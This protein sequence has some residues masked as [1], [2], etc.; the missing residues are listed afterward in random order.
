MQ[1][2][3]ANHFP[4]MHTLNYWSVRQLNADRRLIDPDWMIR[5]SLSQ[6]KQPCPWPNSPHCHFALCCESDAP[7]R[8]RRVSKHTNKK[9]KTSWYG[10]AEALPSP[11]VH[12]WRVV[13]DFQQTESSL[14]PLPHLL[15][16][17]SQPREALTHAVL[18]ERQDPALL[19][20]YILYTRGYI[21]TQLRWGWWWRWLL[22][23]L[24]LLHL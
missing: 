9:G 23:M 11:L 24:Q 2:C 1:M 6:Q 7:V 20:P 18:S 22:L 12:R 21:F 14:S 3:Q 13:I 19:L 16:P 17:Q 8:G 4:C 10:A 15:H 5:P